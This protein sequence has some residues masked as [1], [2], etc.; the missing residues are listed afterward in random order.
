[1]SPDRPLDPMV[2]LYA[3]YKEH[4]RELRNTGYSPREAFWLNFACLPFLPWD[5]D[6]ESEIHLSDLF[7][8]YVGIY[9]KSVDEDLRPE[10]KPAFIELL[11]ERYDMVQS[12]IATT[13]LSRSALELG[14]FVLPCEQNTVRW[15]HAGLTVLHTAD[16]WKKQRQHEPIRCRL[17]DDLDA[18]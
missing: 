1:M 14:R 7:R 12:I 4:V 2:S 5:E 3:F 15:T 9:L 13:H 6:A 18:G 11:R 17:V 8:L 16:E 10:D